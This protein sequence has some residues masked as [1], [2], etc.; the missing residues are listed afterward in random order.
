MFWHRNMPEGW[1]LE[2]QG[3]DYDVRYKKLALVHEGKVIADNYI[4]IWDAGHL[5]RKFRKWAWP[6]H[7]AGVK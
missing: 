1:T 3:P 7:K 2:I 5:T 6:F 4:D